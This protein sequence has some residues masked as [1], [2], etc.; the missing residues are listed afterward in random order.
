M[1]NIVLYPSRLSRLGGT[2]FTSGHKCFRSG[3]PTTPLYTT[4]DFFV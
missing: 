3:N 1:A 4:I 2:T